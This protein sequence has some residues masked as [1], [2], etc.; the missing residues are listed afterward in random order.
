M[1]QTHPIF[2]RRKQFRPGI[3]LGL[4]TM[5]ALLQAL[6][7]PHLHY[8]KILI[9][10]TNGK[11]TT[12]NILSALLG[13]LG[14]SNGLY[15]SPHLIAFNERFQVN[16]RLVR[17][18]ELLYYLK[19]I[20]DVC[21]KEKLH[22]TF[23]E[24]AT[25]VCHCFFRQQDIEL[26]LLEVGMGGRLDATHIGKAELVI[27]TDISQDHTEFL[28]ERLEQIAGEKAAIIPPGGTVISSRQTP[29]VMSVIGKQVARQRATLFLEGRDFQLLSENQGS[30]A[31]QFGSFRMPHIDFSLIGTVFE[32]NLALSL[33]AFSLL[34]KEGWFGKRKL[35]T[36]ES[37]QIQKVLR[38]FQLP[39]RFQVLNLK[40]SQ[41]GKLLLD[42]AHNTKAF[43]ELFLALRNKKV[44]PEQIHLLLA[45]RKGKKWQEMVKQ[46][47]QGLG[48]LTLPKFSCFTDSGNS[49]FIPPE[50]LAQEAH[51]QGLAPFSQINKPASIKESINQAQRKFDEHLMP[52]DFLLA[53]GSLYLIGK[54]LETLE[55][56]LRN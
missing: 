47:P 46:I 51:D 44:V 55:G 20:D 29:E 32:R 19:K 56:N 40:N 49:E 3:H 54:I 36:R 38:N 10:G 52:K 23:F 48:S 7:N 42:G 2:L 16:G 11:G 6:G 34:L 24:I 15:T 35:Q 13:V 28:G 41:E 22:P 12:S 27:L 30:L 43:Q 17:D 8:R 4:E 25:A 33:A 50:T 26:A 39:G 45:I 14:V 1:I 31:F 37:I 5:A 9:A 53:T 21:Q 18:E